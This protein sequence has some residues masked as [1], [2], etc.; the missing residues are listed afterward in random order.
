V[1]GL[2]RFGQLVEGQLPKV[3]IRIDR[4]Q[5][6]KALAAILAQHAIEDIAVEDPPLEEVIADLFS[7]VQHD[8]PVEPEPVVAR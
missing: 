7:Q 1:D 8:A 4:A 5:V 2:E 6:P 3:K